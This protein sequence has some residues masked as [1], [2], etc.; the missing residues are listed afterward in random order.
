MTFQCSDCGY[1]YLTMKELERH[2]D[3]W[4]KNEE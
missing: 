1:R 4:R 3:Y 2:I